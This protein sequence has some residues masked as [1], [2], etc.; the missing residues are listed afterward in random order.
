M[1]PDQKTKPDETPRALLDTLL[2]RWAEVAKAYKAESSDRDDDLARRYSDYRHVYLRNMRD[3]RHVLDTGR[4]PC[5]LMSDAERR[6]GDCGRNHEDEYDP[7]PAPWTPTP[8][9]TT[10]IPDPVRR[11]VVGHLADML[12]SRNDAVLE[13]ARRIAWGLKDEGA[14][15]TEAIKARLTDLTLGRDPS[16]PPF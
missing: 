15:L 16:E 12:L 10:D 5:S 8:D 11:I 7:H 14:D 1:N 4:M 6:R 13:W 9:I 2:D 3:L